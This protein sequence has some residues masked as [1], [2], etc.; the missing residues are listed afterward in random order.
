LAQFGSV[1]NFALLRALDGHDMGF[2]A[3]GRSEAVGSIPI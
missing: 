1:D 3:V 2:R